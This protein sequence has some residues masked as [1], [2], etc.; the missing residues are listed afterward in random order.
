MVQIKENKENPHLEK[1]DI[2]KKE[3]ENERSK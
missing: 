2:K 1:K 3:K